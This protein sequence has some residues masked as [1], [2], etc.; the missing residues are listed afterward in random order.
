MGTATFAGDV[1]ANGNIGVGKNVY[2]DIGSKGGYIMR[3]WGAD[4]LNTTS[5]TQTGA[6]KIVLPT[7]GYEDDMIKF[8]VDVYQYSTNKS[9]S[10]DVGFYVY[11][12]PGGTTL[13]N[14]TAIVNA[15]LANQNWTVRFGDDGTNHCIWIGELDTVWA[16]P[17]I[18]CRDFY[19]GFATETED[20][21]LEWDVTFE[22]TAFEDVQNTLTNNFPLSGGGVDGAYL[23][24]AGGDM[25]GATTHGDS[26]HSYWGN[27]NDLDI[28][29]DNAFGSIIR[30]RG[31][32]DLG[33]ESNQ[34]IRFRKSSTTELMTLMVPDGA[35]SIYY[36]N[37]KKFETTSTGVAVTG[38]GTFTD[39][40][41]IS[42]TSPELYLTNT[43]ALKYNWMVAA[44]E[45]VDQA[46][47]ITP[48]TVVGGS[49][50]NAPAL[51]IDGS[52]SNVT[53][54]ADITA[55]DGTFTGNLIVGTTAGANLSMLR[56][57]ANYINATNATGYLVFRTGGYNTALTLNTAQNATFQGG[58]TIEG[59]FLNL[60]GVAPVMTVDS[61]NTN[62]GFRLNVT[63]LD[64]DSDLLYRLQAASTTVFTVLRGGNAT[65]T[66]LVSGIAPTSDLNF[67]TKKYVDDSITGGA[68]YLG[69]WDPDKTLN[70]GYGNP[71]LQASGRTDDSGDYFICSA[72][73][74]AEPN[75]STA[76]GPE[77]N[78][79]HTGD[80]VIWNEDLAGGSWQKLDNTTVLSGGGTTDY[81]ARFTD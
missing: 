3:P 23:P 66:G 75:G 11:Q 70:S 41:T 46:F 36:D 27:S 65:F 12:A 67:A 15:K 68:N 19:G 54:A 5:Q 58:A 22:A 14:C 9:F 61:S 55:V 33:I 25:T 6:I 76:P 45:N 74:I 29:H 32:G 13:L 42:N 52:T 73:G 38:S 1:I 16:Y 34:A 43:N 21:L 62:S 69:V 60:N 28:Y 72:D 49:T 59:G 56:N 78:S 20:Y 57:S 50:Y 2:Q 8:T 30:D 26:V 80:W 48:S 51:R 81:V 31:A 4:F 37:S 18:I 39:D 40:I 47:E 24:L 35:V 53:F 64:T 77:P 17:Q 63:G 44:Q 71:S 79:W 7:T 10:V